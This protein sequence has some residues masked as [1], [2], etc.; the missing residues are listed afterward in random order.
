MTVLSLAPSGFYQFYY[1][2]RDG[3]W[4]A[5]SPEITSGGVI[6]T[7]AWARLGPDLIFLGGALLLFVFVA[8]AIYMT[9]KEATN[10][11]SIAAVSST[12][13]S[14]KSPAPTKTLK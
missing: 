5:R 11:S 4:Y 6:R 13:E 7:L 14:S 8:R 2:V 10:A 3:L 9:I 1:A 12:G